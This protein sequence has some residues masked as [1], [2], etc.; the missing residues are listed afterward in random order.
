M[1]LKKLAVCVLI[2]LAIVSITVSSQSSKGEGKVLWEYNT[3]G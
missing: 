2:F 3:G 1:I